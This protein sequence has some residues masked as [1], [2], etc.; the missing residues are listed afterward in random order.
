MKDTQ[1]HYRRNNLAQIHIL[2]KALGWD[3]DLYRDVLENLTG[4]RSTKDMSIK[5]R[6]K[7]IN[8]MEGV[9][10]NSEVRID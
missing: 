4:K 5:D 8:H 6:W 9:L 2:K 3:D 7:V 10:L 1:Q